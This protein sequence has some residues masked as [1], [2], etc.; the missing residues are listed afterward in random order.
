MFVTFLMISKN[1]NIFPN[2]F[3]ALKVNKFFSSL[4]VALS[5]KNENIIDKFYF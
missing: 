5:L 3:D 2:E 1:K 4:I